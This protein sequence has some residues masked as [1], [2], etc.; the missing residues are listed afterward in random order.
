MMK[1]IRYH[2]NGHFIEDRMPF[3]DKKDRLF[4]HFPVHHQMQK[5]VETFDELIE[6]IGKFLSSY[7]TD[8]KFCYGLVLGISEESSLVE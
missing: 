5:D 7:T 2:I 1:K 8:P 6:T 3:V 4:D